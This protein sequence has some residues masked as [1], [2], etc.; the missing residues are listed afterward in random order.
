[1]MLFLMILLFS[2]EHHGEIQLIILLFILDMNMIQNMD[3]LDD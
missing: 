1:M 3:R 2:I